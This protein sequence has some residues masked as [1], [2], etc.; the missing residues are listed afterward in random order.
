M[1]TLVIGRSPFADIL[2]VDATVAPHHA[3]LVVTDDGRF[4]LTDRASP[5]GTWRR[6]ASGDDWIPLRQDFVRADEP[7]RFGG[8]VAVAADLVRMARPACGAADCDRSGS[9]DQG[10]GTGGGP[11]RRDAEREP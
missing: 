4:Y 5:G 11:S 10:E 1:R 6:A 3:E 9:A 8:H 7:L 2:L